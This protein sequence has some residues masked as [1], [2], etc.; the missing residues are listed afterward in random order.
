MTQLQNQYL[1]TQGEIES[2]ESQARQ[3]QQHMDQLLSSLAGTVDISAPM[4]D[5]VSAA[6][7]RPAAF[8]NAV[9]QLCSQVFLCV[10][11]SPFLCT[12][13]SYGSELCKGTK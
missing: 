11:T 1:S 2:L 10:P 9:Q 4:L 3:R 13:A 6:M 8:P 5:A 12:A 7:E